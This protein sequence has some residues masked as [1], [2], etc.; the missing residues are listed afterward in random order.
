M[1][2]KQARRDVP[3]DGLTVVSILIDRDEVGERR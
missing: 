1:P 3:D 2:R